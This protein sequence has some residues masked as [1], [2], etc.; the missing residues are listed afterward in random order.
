MTGWD[1][2]VST[3]LL[4]TDRKPPVRDGLPEPVRARL[5]D[6][7]DPPRV[8]LDAAALAAAYRRAGRRPM[9]GPIPLPAATRD[10]RPVPGDAA[11]RRLAAMLA[12]E[13]STVLAEWLRVVNEHGWR[14][15]PEF[16]PAL[17]DLTRGRT[18]LRAAVRRAA[19][20]RAGWLAALNPDWR[21][22]EEEVA[23]GKD[24]W[25][26][27]TPGQRR[28]WLTTTRGTDPD[29]AR[30]VLRA[31]WPNEPA[32]TRAELLAILA[33]GLSPADEEFCETA[34]DDRAAEVRRVAARLLAGVPGS[35]YGKRMAERVRACLSVP[36][37]GLLRVT[38]P[39]E[40]DD[41]MRRDG[42][43]I[44]PPQ[45]VGERAWWFSQL[46]AA[47]P[48]PPSPGEYLGPEI[49]G[50]EPDL[51]YAALATAAARERNA[52]WALALLR[53]AP[54]A[55]PR[56]AELVAILPRGRWAVTVAEVHEAVD[57]ADV[58]GGLP[59]PWP[60]N[61]A[62][63]LLDV[64]DAATADRSLARLASVTARAVPP[65]VLAAG[66]PLMRE[67]DD[68]DDTEDTWR[69]RLA[70]TLVFRREMYEELS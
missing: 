3:A 27:G 12:G 13:H 35:A 59:Q 19:G 53:T 37:R 67:P 1:D 64:L 60:P 33:D 43:A 47:A 25:E 57:V 18:E 34:L 46:V 63:M 65:E 7:P 40:H 26:H 56:T 58:V 55:G 11:V 61:L 8:L 66:H 68:P 32:E 70:E 5:S 44:R 15:P 20:P 49:E 38:L 45:G 6:A 22:L 21:Y 9:R 36:R 54:A 69:R 2:L 23:E 30:E 48:L 42:I 16:L 31:T 51:L 4:G 50:C 39:D 14:I 41:G 24:A 17:A 28:R 62:M 10:D 29:G 52:D